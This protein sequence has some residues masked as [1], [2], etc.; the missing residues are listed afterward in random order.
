MNGTESMT[1]AEAGTPDPAQ[2]PGLQPGLATTEGLASLLGER[3]F[4]LRQ[5]LLRAHR[6][7]NRRIAEKFGER[8]YAQIRPPH[9]TVLSNMN[10]GSTSVLDLADRAQTTG[11]AIEQLAGELEELGLVT[12]GPDRGGAILIAFTDAGWELMLTSFNIQREIES[13]CSDRLRAGDLDELRR[14]LDSMLPS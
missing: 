13:E 9:L 3:E 6:A 4:N 7:M 1:A 12:A 2:A 11:Q 5:V 14:I 8:G 10:L